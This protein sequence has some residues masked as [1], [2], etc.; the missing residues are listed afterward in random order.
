M[1]NFYDGVPTSYLKYL[2]CF[3][4]NLA[5]VFAFQV[6]CQYERSGKYIMQ[7]KFTQVSSLMDLIFDLRDPSWL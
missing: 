7:L 4:P 5:L 2:L 1:I 6:I 3:F